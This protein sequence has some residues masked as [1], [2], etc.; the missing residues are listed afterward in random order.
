MPD[1][2]HL[3]IQLVLPKGCAGIEVRAGPGNLLKGHI[4]GGI[5]IFFGI[6]T[7]RYEG[8]FLKLAKKQCAAYI[9]NSSVRSCNVQCPAAKTH[10]TRRAEGV[11]RA[12][13]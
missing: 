3:Q 12:L 8:R 7:S 2:A 4:S 10:A 11:R 9:W 13:A 6:V 5:V 1:A